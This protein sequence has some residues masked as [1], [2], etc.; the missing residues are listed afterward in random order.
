M[1][2]RINPLGKTTHHRPPGTRE[3]VTELLGQA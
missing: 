3:C 1:S 2:R